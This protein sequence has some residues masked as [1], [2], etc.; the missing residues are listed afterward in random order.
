MVFVTPHLCIS[1]CRALFPVNVLIILVTINWPVQSTEFC[2]PRGQSLPDYINCPTKTCHQHI[3][4]WVSFGPP[5][6]CVCDPHLCGAVCLPAENAKCP[7]LKP[8]KMGSISYNNTDVGEV[9]T[10]R[11][12]S[13][14]VVRG[15][16]MRYCLATLSWS[17]EDP[18]CSNE[19]NTCFSPPYMPNTFVSYNR[20]TKVRTDASDRSTI[21]ARDDYKSGDVVEISCLPGY[22]DPLMTHA[23]ASCIGSEWRYD[24]IACERITCGP[25]HEIAHGHIVYKSDKKYQSDALAMCSDGYVADC[26]MEN[27]M[28][29]DGKGCIRVCQ[30]DGSWSGRDA[31]CRK[32]TCPKLKPIKNGEVSSYSTE[33]NGVVQFYCH[34]GYELVGCSQRTCS[35]SGVWDG[36][37]PICKERDCGPPPVVRRGKL[38]YNSTKF[39]S[40]AVIECEAET[41]L[42]T[43]S[44]FLKCGLLGNNTSWI[45]KPQPACNQH[46]YLFTV[47]HGDVILMHQRNSSDAKMIPIK[48]EAYEPSKFATDKIGTSDGIILPGGRVRHGSELNV[49]C[50]PGYELA[51][52]EFPV[53]T[54]N[55]GVWT[56]RS[57]CVPA[58]CATR[59]PAAKSSRVRFYSRK[60]KSNA[61][62]ECFP[63]YVL[64]VDENRMREQF[65][66]EDTNDPKGTIRCLYGRWVGVPVYCEPTHCPRLIVSSLVDVEL[67]IPR[68]ASPSTR[69]EPVQGTF[70]HFR[71][72]RGYHILGPRFSMCHNGSW[73]PPAQPQCQQSTHDVIP[74]E[75]L[76][77]IP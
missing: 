12:E 31:I 74:V 37:D 50:R 20:N 43:T 76:F 26:G 41:T 28:T 63:G 61:R 16:R 59:P 35:A 33:V 75:W 13:G 64:Q 54:C 1:L 5:Q 52:P 7:E 17:G 51:Q 66:T 58:S 8:P 55:D 67:K 11:C 48:A 49:T 21:T 9:A 46:C 60:H 69:S 34:E 2:E 3:D 40:R 29:E 24:K 53:T 77:R 57:K 22:N 15:P 65:P 71:C 10:Y 47:D 27:K 36:E 70:A 68:F 32:I 72:P 44:Q 38:N 19:T 30:S 25:M 73:T 4:C 18:T 42:T 56:V 62:Y 6:S 45:P 14:L 23:V 39:G